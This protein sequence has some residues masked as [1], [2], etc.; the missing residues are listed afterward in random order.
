MSTINT[1]GALSPRTAAYVVVDLLERGMPYLVFEKFGQSKPIPRRSS[2]T[3]KFRRY[4]LSMNSATFSPYAYFQTD[5]QNNF[6]PSEK[7]LTEGVTP[8]ATKLESTDYT[9]TLVQ[10]GLA[11]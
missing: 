3:I 10:Y 7:T 11:A 2:K 9:A 4:Y 6:S 8:D 5:A 1:Y